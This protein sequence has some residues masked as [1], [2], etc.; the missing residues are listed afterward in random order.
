MKIRRVL[1]LLLAAVLL[2]TCSCQKPPHGQEVS[3]DGEMT[4]QP[5]PQRMAY[6]FGEAMRVGEDIY[7]MEGVSFSKAPIYAAEYGAENF[8]PYIPCFDAVCNHRD[9]TKCCLAT[10]SVGGGI[11]QFSA[12][13]YDGD[14]AL[15][16]F[17]ELDIS[18]SRPYSN[19]KRNLVF[20][21]FINDPYP[22][23][24]D[25]ILAYLEAISSAP[26]KSEP[27]VYGDHLYYVE[28]KNGVR[29][30]Y[31]I[32]LEGGE[33]E[34]VFDEDNIIIKTIIND[35]FYGIRYENVDPNDPWEALLDRDNLNY[36]RSDMNYE[37]IEDLP[38]ILDF[39][40]LR[41]EDH[42]TPKSNT[43]L[44]ADADYIYVLNGMKVWKISDSDIYAEPI[45]LSDMEGKVP[46][47][48]SADLW[49]TS[50]YNDG[51][52]YT[53]LNIGL[54]GRS[55]LDQNG[56]ANSM[57]WY[58]SSTLYSF[59]IETGECSSVDIS[60][61]SYLITKILY[62]DG[63]Y[64]YGEGRYAHDDGRGIQGVTIRLTLDTMRYE[65]ILPDRF[66]EYSAETAAE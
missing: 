22:T 35:R 44:Y 13:S 46:Y 17:N 31:R 66:F 62:A 14:V 42:F 56:F 24:A 51:Y 15:V 54:Q 19:I 50:W 1:L 34:R 10:T 41:G 11:D 37:N 3:S 6:H 61:Q 48:Q 27:L 45:M 7:F 18:F 60:S 52:I 40:T 5:E 25:G 64:V 57:Q 2:L 33:P 65:V 8:E 43:I 4:V 28:L 26:Q 59:N 9:R 30:Q 12:F 49:Q 39:F 36:F 63:E 29:T 21:D 53:V 20:E 58:E 32:L 47:E 23:D 16:I 38:E 55:L